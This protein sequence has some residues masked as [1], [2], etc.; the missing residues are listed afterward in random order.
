MQGTKF[1]DIP[2][3]LRKL[4][5]CLVC[6]GS[7]I[8][9]SGVHKFCSES[10]KGKWKYITGN[11]TSKTQYNNISGRWDQYFNRLVRMHDR[12]RDG[13]TTE[14]LLRILQKQDYKCALSGV[15]LTCLLEVGT[16]FKTNASIDRIEPGGP[17]VEENIQL[18]CSV[19]NKF[20]TD[21]D[22]QEYIWW[23]KQV[24]EHHK[25]V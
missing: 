25:E 21:T 24:A 7:F 16:K 5:E 6:K 22:L 10:C 18:V 3:E 15:K 23:C 20:R 17:Y 11:V 13:L 8:P 14:M 4:K 12:K 9:N 19:L 2:K 1:T